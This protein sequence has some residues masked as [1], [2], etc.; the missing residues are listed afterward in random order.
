[1]ASPVP[2]IGGQS[3]ATVLLIQE[4]LLNETSDGPAQRWA[5]MAAEN[6]IYIEFACLALWLVV[7]LS[8]LFSCRNCRELSASCGE[9]TLTGL[10]LVSSSF[11]KCSLLLGLAGF[12]EVLVVLH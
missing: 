4:M 10:N 3:L 2:N 5:S 12:V 9:D 1:M 8:M 6:V 7:P 11:L